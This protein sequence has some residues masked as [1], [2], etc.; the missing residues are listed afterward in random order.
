MARRRIN[1]GE[2]ALFIGPNRLTGDIS[3]G[4]MI[5]LIR[6]QS[7]DHTFSIP[8]QP[9]PSLGTLSSPDVAVEPAIVECNIEY[10]TTNGS[11]ESAIGFVTDGSI[12][13]FHNLS[14]DQR[15]LFKRFEND[16]GPNDPMTMTFGHMALTSYE[17]NAQVNQP[18]RSR[19]NY[20]GYEAAFIN[21]TT[22]F[23]PYINL[24][25][26]ENI[27]DYTFSVPAHN[28]NYN[29][30]TTGNL[31][32]NAI[33]T[34]GNILLTYPSSGA[35]AVNLTNT[36]TVFI[37]GFSVN[38]NFPRNEPFKVRQRFPIARGIQY[39]ITVN[40]TT[41]LTMSEN[42]VD[43]FQQSVNRTGD[44]VLEVKANGCD[45]GYD[46]H[47]NQGDVTAIKYTL[48]GAKLTSQ[49]QSMS[50]GGTVN[51][52]LGWTATLGN[53]TSLQDNF[54]I[55]GNHG[56][57]AYVFKE[58]VSGDGLAV[59]T[60]YEV[61]IVDS[62]FLYGLVKKDMDIKDFDLQFLNFPT[63]NSATYT[64][65]FMYQGDTGIFDATGMI[66]SGLTETFDNW[67]KAYGAG[68]LNNGGLVPSYTGM[69]IPYNWGW[70]SGW[71]ERQ[72]EFP[73]LIALNSFNDDN[74][75]LRVEGLPSGISGGFYEPNVQLDPNR[76][77]YFNS[78][79]LKATDQEFPIANKRDFQIIAESKQMRKVIPVSIQTEEAYHITLL[80]E[81]YGLF[82]TWIDAYDRFSYQMDEGIPY[83]S[84]EDPY[85]HFDYMLD[86]SSG[87][88]F[89]LHNEDISNKAYMLTD[90]FANKTTVA[91]R[92]DQ[93]TYRLITS[94]L[95]YD[96]NFDEFTVMFLGSIKERNDSNLP[97]LVW[98]GQTYLDLGNGFAYS[99]SGTYGVFQTSGENILVTGAFD[100]DVHL[101]TLV[102][103]GTNLTVRRD[104]EEV[105]SFIPTDPISRI[106]GAGMATYRYGKG[107]FME[108]LVGS[109]QITGQTLDLL[110]NY[111]ETKW[112]YNWGTGNGYWE[113]NR[114]DI[115]EYPNLVASGQGF[116]CNFN[117]SGT[118]Y[119]G[120]SGIIGYCDGDGYV[121]A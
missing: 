72:N 52:S 16:E 70:P 59:P 55:S 86:K 61:D 27:N 90:S 6:V 31:G 97:S 101:H 28:S 91:V 48:R 54:Y 117:L 71:I 64:D 22:G 36:S 10:F 13:A 37:Q 14:R 75:N 110:E 11:N 96:R 67:S 18:M 43:S 121:W 46:E 34:A 66:G 8:K 50:V 120:Q 88:F 78:L 60:G 77:Y 87:A 89:S 2:E 38:A 32:T 1:Y 63:I 42:Q 100:D 39:P 81:Y 12:G 41:D 105:G 68:V 111:F 115:F 24:S 104:G 40:V 79:K 93:D 4:E 3:S 35:F 103:N 119:Y 19:I 15:H 113:F 102:Y 112:H 30:R 82:H 107:R 47:W 94:G 65:G 108:L 20:R 76:S 51:V 116:I 83:F 118:P 98:F 106:S 62:Q 69:I 23:T 56:D 99:R 17:V 21:G 84:R 49:S 109:G 85:Y 95:L 9:V 58:Y 5:E 53:S 57:L 73:L 114:P 33:N 26:G 80:P 29:D 92:N 45:C 44:I 7:S 74:I 25:G